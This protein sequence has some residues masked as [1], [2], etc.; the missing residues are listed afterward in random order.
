MKTYLSVVFA[1]HRKVRG[2]F[3]P[4]FPRIATYI[5]IDC[6]VPYAIAVETPC[7]IPR[8]Q[9]VLYPYIHALLFPTQML[10][11]ILFS[12]KNFETQYLKWGFEI[13]KSLQS[14]V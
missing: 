7:Q 11:Y 4:K 1:P 2:F 12:A 10:E 14:M 3:M 8:G 5:L 13:L 9:F 6:C